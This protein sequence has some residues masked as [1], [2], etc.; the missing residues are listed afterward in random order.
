MDPLENLKS[1]GLIFP[2]YVVFISLKFGFVS[3]NSAD[4]DEMQHYS[5]F[6][7]SS[8]LSKVLVYEFSL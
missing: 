6:H 2:N 8:L 3:A 4:H 7:L 5:A 1:Q